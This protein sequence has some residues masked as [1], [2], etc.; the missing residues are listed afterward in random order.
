[1]LVCVCVYVGV[2]GW[3]GRLRSEELGA[4]ALRRLLCSGRARCR[5]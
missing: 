2:C 5:C 4:W 1:M 3:G